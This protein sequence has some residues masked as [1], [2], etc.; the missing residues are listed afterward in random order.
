MTMD[1]K[2]LLTRDGR[3][4]RWATFVAGALKT[5]CHGTVPTTISLLRWLAHTS[6]LDWRSGN[7][8][9]NSVPYAM[10][11]LRCQYP[12]SHNEHSVKRRQPL[13]LKSMN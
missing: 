2:R 8:I 10:Y 1:S 11:I 12:H 13:Q 3:M 6:T 7:A 4:G 9:F 5:A